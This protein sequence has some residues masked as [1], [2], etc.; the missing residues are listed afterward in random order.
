M[1]TL[2]ANTSN[3]ALTPVPFPGQER[4]HPV[5]QFP[6]GAGEATKCLRVTE[7]AI[8]QVAQA[9]FTTRAWLTHYGAPHYGITSL[10]CIIRLCEAAQGRAGSEELSGLP[11]GWGARRLGHY[12][13]IFHS[14]EVEAKKA[15]CALPERTGRRAVIPAKLVEMIRR[16]VSKDLKRGDQRKL[17]ARIGVSESHVSRIINGLRRRRE[18]SSPSNENFVHP[19]Q[20]GIAAIS[21]ALVD[22]VFEVFM[23]VKE[24]RD[25][26][27]NPIYGIN[28]ISC[29][30]QKCSGKLWENSKRPARLPEEW[31][32][33]RIGKSWLI[34]H[35]SL[36]PKKLVAARASC[37]GTRESSKHAA[38][39]LAGNVNTPMRP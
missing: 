37:S 8:A 1:P 13:Y 10:S 2:P 11:S 24:W 14:S 34:Y 28:S 27:G 33:I 32:T 38:L 22:S 36:L 26:V 23:T 15:E 16:E 18:C 6:H 5:L 12:W 7:K 30:N 21:P 17:A 3:C 39:G 29:V 35:R 25:H 19:R 31:F 20:L 9:V 4:V